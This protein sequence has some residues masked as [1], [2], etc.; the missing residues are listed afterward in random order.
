M[1]EYRFTIVWALRSEVRERG[2]RALSKGGHDI[3]AE[4]PEAAERR[5]EQEF[6]DCVSWAVWHGIDYNLDPDPR[7]LVNN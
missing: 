5:F 6:P 7:G 2:S 3:M 4:S 1:R